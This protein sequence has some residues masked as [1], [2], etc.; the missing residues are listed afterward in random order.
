MAE[1]FLDK[2]KQ[3]YS[4]KVRGMQS[5]YNVTQLLE[6]EEFFPWVECFRETIPNSR[7]DGRE[8]ID[9]IVYSDEEFSVN[10]GLDTLALQIKS[11][12][13]ELMQFMGVLSANGKSN[14]HRFLKKTSREWVA[15]S[16]VIVD[17]QWPITMMS[18]D[19]IYQICA[20]SGLW[21]DHDRMVRFV[22]DNFT[23]QATQAVISSVARIYDYRGLFLDWVSDGYKQLE[24][25]PC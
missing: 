14:K 6:D 24:N 11:S 15:T 20:L 2:G 16:M 8:K 19:I 22:S 13:A 10:T 21:P 17:G 23:E 4:N 3:E 25:R 7:L 5:V 18:A 9:L 12:E 1:I